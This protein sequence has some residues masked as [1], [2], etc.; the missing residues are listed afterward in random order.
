M[1]LPHP[2]WEELRRNGDKNIYENFIDSSG[3]GRTVSMVKEAKCFSD[4]LGVFGFEIQQAREWKVFLSM[5]KV[6]NDELARMTFHWG[7]YALL[8]PWRMFVQFGWKK[9]RA[10]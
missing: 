3:F 4:L 8:H 7:L 2:R 1:F 10:P 6:H 9:G 5:L